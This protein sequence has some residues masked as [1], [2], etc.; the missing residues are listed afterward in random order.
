MSAVAPAV[1]RSV[2]TVVEG[3]VDDEAA[4]AFCALLLLRFLFLLE[5]PLG[6]LKKLG[7]YRVAIGIMMDKVSYSSSYFQMSSERIG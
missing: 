1:P 7:T 4:A 5:A 3:A 6:A 2:S